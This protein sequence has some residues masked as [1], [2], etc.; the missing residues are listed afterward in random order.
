M[1]GSTTFGVG[2]NWTP[3]EKT[4]SVCNTGG[5]NLSVSS[6]SINCSDFTAIANPF[7]AKVSPDSCLQLAL[8]F[9]PTLP[10]AVGCQLTIAS[11]DPDTPSVTR[12]L[13]AHTPPSLSLHA[14]VVEPHG[15]IH[16]VARLGSTFTLD[17]VYPFQPNWA[18][19]VRLGYSRFDGRPGQPDVNVWNV[20]ANVKYTL[21]PAAL[22]RFFVNGGG[23]LYHFTPGAREAGFNLGAGINIPVKPRFALE[24]SYNYHQ[25]FTA[26]PDL[27][28]SQFQ[29]GLLATF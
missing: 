10:G 21:N 1:T 2:S 5:C 18:W 8:A 12:P 4:I 9:T 16:S 22:Q 19:D 11:D 13:T 20:L 15:A 17:F 6:A 26:S 7:P 14:G 3:S 24:G 23:G 25:A 29:V 27:K 28:F